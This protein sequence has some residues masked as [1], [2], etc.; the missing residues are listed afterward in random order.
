MDSE[1]KPVHGEIVG[2]IIPPPVVRAIVDKTASFV[3]KHGR[4]FENKISG[5]AQAGS[6]KFQFLD[7]SNP[8]H[9]YYEEK[10]KELSE[11]AEQPEDAGAAGGAAGDAAAKEE[12]AA[13]TSGDHTDTVTGPAM[14][15]APA[16]AEGEKRVENKAALSLLARIQPS[17]KRSDGFLSHDTFRVQHPGTITVLVSET[18]KLTAQFTA[19][20]G[21]SFLSGIVAREGTNPLFEFLKPGSVYFHYFTALVDS[22]TRCLQPSEEV[23]SVIDDYSQVSDSKHAGHICLEDCISKFFLEKKKI[24]DQRRE[25]ALAGEEEAIARIDWHDFVVV[26]TITFD[27]DAE[28]SNEDKVEILANK[29]GNTQG[30]RDAVSGGS[31]MEDSNSDMENSEEDSGMDMDSDDEQGGDDAASS[32]PVRADYKPNI[33]GRTIPQQRVLDPKSGKALP[34]NQI[35]EHMRIE[36]L[37]PK[38][39]EE[40]MKAAEKQ[41]TTNVAAGDSISDNLKRF[42]TKR[43]EILSGVAPADAGPGSKAKDQQV[44]WDGNYNSAKRVQEAARKA[45]ENAATNAGA[46]TGPQLPEANGEERDAKR[47]RKQ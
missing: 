11:S 29:K 32:L 28:N 20:A 22:Y 46:V 13:T 7:P 4:A 17:A 45:A 34:V 44:V 5:S 40:Q 12:P 6:S 39:R 31:D 9:K 14:T 3:A 27:N 15:N 35:G 25:A 18:I 26:Q 37:H 10:I 2:L 30:G 16:S 1:T 36:L 41:K 38:W 47:Q 19:L 43:N 8:Y 24:E 23:K 33:S 21:E 42:A